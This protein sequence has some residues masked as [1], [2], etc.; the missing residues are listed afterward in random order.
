MIIFALR[1]ADRV[2]DDV[3]ALSDKGKA[4]ADLL[5]RML[6]PGHVSNAYCSD[7][8]RTQATIAPLKTMLGAGLKVNVVPVGSGGPAAHAQAIVSALNAL[9][10]DSTAVVVGH[11]NTIDLIIKALTGKVITPIG[12]NEFDNLFVLS[13]PAG[14]PSLTLLKYGAPT[15]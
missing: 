14:S 6:A 9:P 10:A 7:A 1:H 11:S 3:D 5:A 13:V 2:S 12:P 8:K 15:P 4:R